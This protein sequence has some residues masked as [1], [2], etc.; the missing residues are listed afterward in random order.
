MTTKGWLSTAGIHLYHSPGD[1]ISEVK[2][3]AKPF[4]TQREIPRGRTIFW[5][6]QVSPGCDPITP[7]S[8]SVVTMPPAPA[9]VMSS[10]SLPLVWMLMMAF[11]AQVSQG[12]LLNS[13]NLATSAKALFPKG[14][15]SKLRDC[16]LDIFRGP[17]VSFQQ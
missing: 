13:P 10:L 4:S 11:K 8:A 2:V 5:W 6:P 12:Q 15:I 16:Y 9:S 1:Q 14:H 7:I 17:Y 3:S